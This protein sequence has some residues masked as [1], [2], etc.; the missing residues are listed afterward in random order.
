M[1]PT[2]D[3]NVVTIITCLIASV[4]AT[5]VALINSN[6]R[7]AKSEQKM[8]DAI[9]NLNKEL[10]GA[11]KRIEELSDTDNCCASLKVDVDD[12]KGEM[13]AMA[14]LLNQFKATSDANDEMIK[15]G[16]KNFA[17]DRLNQ[18]HRYFMN[19]GYIDEKSKESLH[20]V[21]KTYKDCKGNTFIDG[22]MKDI[23]EL[24]EVNSLVMKLPKSV[25]KGILK[26]LFLK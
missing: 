20:A 7:Q 16:F 22:E 6:S 13:Q 14:A 24:P 10:S 12:I 18:G 4:S 15:E 3:P 5:L 2:V 8:L 23:D 1:P 25:K 21:Y 11:K 19:L 26:K 9:E 17:K